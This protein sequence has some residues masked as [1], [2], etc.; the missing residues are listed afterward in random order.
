MERAKWIALIMFAMVLS[1]I[2]PLSAQNLPESSR[3]NSGEQLLVLRN[4][5]LLAG[6]IKRERDFYSVQTRTGSRLRIPLDEASFVCGSFDE[7]YWGKLARLKATDQTG[8]I[9]LFRWCI[10]QQLLTLAENQITILEGLRLAP[11]ELDFM[12]R[13]LMMSHRERLERAR[14]ST[15]QAS[16]P[17]VGSASSLDELDHVFSPLPSM[18]IDHEPAIRQVAYDEPTRA[19]SSLSFHN[20]FQTQGNA[21]LNSAK[22]EIAPATIRRPSALVEPEKLSGLESRNAQPLNVDGVVTALSA[23]NPATVPDW[24]PSISA[25]SPAAADSKPLSPLGSK[26]GEIPQLNSRPAVFRPRDDFDPEIFN[27]ECLP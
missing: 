16:V 7:A 11:N 24:P 27:R 17:S 2:R 20:P 10:Q 6:F 18:D 26:I 3:V 5:G 19:D 25:T 23:S 4:G 21:E 13:Q 15:Q 8:Q 12:K 22:S 14:V 1:T 9:A